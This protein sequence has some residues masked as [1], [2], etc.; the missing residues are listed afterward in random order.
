V[1]WPVVAA[2]F[3]AYFAREFPYGPGQ[4]AVRPAD[5]TRALAEAAM[6]FNVGLWSNDT[7]KATAYL[8][9]AAHILKK[10]I[11]AAGGLL[12]QGGGK[13]LKSAT[14]G[15]VTSK[16]VGSVSVTEDFPPWIKD[17]PILG[18]YLTSPFGQRY[19][20]LV[21]PRIRG[22]I[23]TVAGYPGVISGE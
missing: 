15:L 19:L 11:D 7:E 10:N 13:G 5:V 22:N 6:E 1:V 17:D 4:D 9:L 18:P 8:Y 12:P 21:I 2:D 16:S 3:N 23:G 14:R 20:V